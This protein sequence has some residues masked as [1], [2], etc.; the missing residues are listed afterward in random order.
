MD[1]THAHAH[2]GGVDRKRDSRSATT[3]ATTMSN[4][5]GGPAPTTIQDASPF[6]RQSAWQIGTIRLQGQ[7]V[8]VK[9]HYLLPLYW[10]FSLIMG[11]F[12]GGIY[13]GYLI[14][15]DVL[16]LFLTVFVHEI[17]HR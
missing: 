11:I 5:S 4:P 15:T 12:R 14:V 2:A 3:T 8:P 10:V 9:V 1:R 16:I 13:F 7:T 17:G 6:P